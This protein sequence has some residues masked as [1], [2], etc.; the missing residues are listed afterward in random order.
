MRSVDCLSVSPFCAQSP[1]RERCGAQV[2]QARIQDLALLL[3]VCDHG[4][5]TLKTGGR[6]KCKGRHVCV[7]VCVCIYLSELLPLSLLLMFLLGFEGRTGV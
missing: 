5:S 4:E 7:F 3:T 6:Q 2:R 1:F